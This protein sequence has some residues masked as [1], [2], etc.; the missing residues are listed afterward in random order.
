[1]GLAAWPLPMLKNTISAPQMIVE[2]LI[3]GLRERGHEVI[4]FS[5]KDGD[6][7]G[8][9]DSIDLN[10]SNK[11]FGPE[12]ENPVVFTERK[13]ELDLIFAKEAIK[14]HQNGKLDLINT[15][16]V[17]YNP[18]V[19]EDSELPVIYTPHTN[20]EIRYHDYDKYRYKMIVQ[21]GNLGFANISKKN[22]EFCKN[23]GAKVYGYVPNGIDHNR[24]SY[25]DENRKGLLLVGRIVPGKKIEEAI[26]IAESLGET[27]TIVGPPGSKDPDKEYF[28]KMKKEY[29]NR[30]NVDYVGPKFGSDLVKYYKKAKVLIY[31]SE[32]EGLPLGVLEAM[33]TGLPA[34]ASNVGG[35]PDIIDD[36]VDGILVDGFDVETWRRGIENG[37]KIKSK[38]CRDK[39]EKKFTIEKM[40]DN[41]EIAYQ[42]IVSNKEAS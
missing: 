20:L 24:F 11:E 17:R 32:S 8:K 14:M 6:I 28:S 22:N 33:S 37:L 30:D 25:S 1:M 40:I 21:S 34:V 38:S 27:I 12:I 15:H 36:G 41:Y 4:V 13:I 10:S 42:N 18:Y 2:N 16:D 39:I 19:F 9:V 5:G 7:D 35:V 26:N 31:P 23:L 3:N 29:F